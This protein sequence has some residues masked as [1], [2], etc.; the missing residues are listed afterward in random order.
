MEK[1]Q[2]KENLKN[3]NVGLL[4]PPDGGWGWVVCL[5]CFMC[6]FIMDGISYSF[7][8]L[9][10]PLKVYFNA[11]SSDIAWAGSLITGVYYMFGLV[12]SGLVAKYGCRPVCMVGGLLAAGALATST[13]TSGT[14]AFICLYGCIGGIGLGLI[15]T[16]AQIACSYYFEK[17]RAL[18]TG[19]SAGRPS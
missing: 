18:A 4:Q 2:S 14:I 6:N 3:I 13:L 15:Y 16:P 17:K 9:M 1:S 8:M 10:E 12:A 7:S 11:S 5:A 19:I